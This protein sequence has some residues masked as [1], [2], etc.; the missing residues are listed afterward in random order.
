MVYLLTSLC[1][2]NKN[3]YSIVVWWIVLYIS[4]KSR[5]LILFFKSIISLM[6][7]H[8]LVLS[9]IERRVFITPIT[10]V[11]LLISPCSYVCIVRSSI[12]VKNLCLEA[13]QII[14]WL[15]MWLSLS[16]FLFIFYLSDVF[17]IPPSFCLL[18]VKY[19]LYSTLP[20]LLICYNS[21]SYYFQV[22]N[23]HL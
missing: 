3:E 2:T 7:F 15:S 19:V 17:P 4:I 16:N 10:T 5:W 8:L 23:T 1:T 6:I 11:D 18:L 12:T 14:T 9:V 21:L 20:P 22:Y 13:R